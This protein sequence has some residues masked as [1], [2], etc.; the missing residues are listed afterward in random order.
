MIFLKK[1]AKFMRLFLMAIA[2]VVLYLMVIKYVSDIFHF[3]GQFSDLLKIVAFAGSCAFLWILSE[4][5]DA[6]SVVDTP[7]ESI[8][9]P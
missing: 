4:P 9:N 7:A 1:A 2:S 8:A 5:K 3:K 6:A